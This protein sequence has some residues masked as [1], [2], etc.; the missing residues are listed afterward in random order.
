[1]FDDIAAIE[2][3]L[4]QEFEM[5]S[6]LIELKADDYPFFNSN[7]S[8]EQ[9]QRFAREVEQL[10][11]VNQVTL[12]DELTSPSNGVAQFVARSHY[13]QRGRDIYIS[14]QPY[15]LVSR[16]LGTTHGSVYSYDQHVPII[17]L[18]G[19]LESGLIEDKVST[20]DIAPT[21]AKILNIQ[22]DKFDGKVL[23]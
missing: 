6:P 14:F 1:V 15:T 22:Y 18:G 7:L 17:F 3:R 12:A 8:F 2:E 13:H 23:P 16:S 4:R 11:Y 10:D 9:K 20:T 5:D 19:G 21:L